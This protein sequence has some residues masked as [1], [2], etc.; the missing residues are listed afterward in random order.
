[1][2][3]I[4]VVGVAS[5]HLSQLVALVAQNR[6]G[7]LCFSLWVGLGIYL[8][9]HSDV[10]G[11]CR[12]DLFPLNCPLNRFTPLKFFL[13]E[14]N[15]PEILPSFCF[16]SSS[17]DSSTVWSFRF[18]LQ[19]S[20]LGIPPLFTFK[21]DPLLANVSILIQTAISYCDWLYL[22]ASPEWP[23]LQS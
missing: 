9:T 6:R 17:K 14:I 12:V 21:L 18:M 19:W 8:W 11:R 5:N 2:E 20:M 7:L 1:M 15:Y 4:H 16:F 13:D 23:F 22:H 10:I 3:F